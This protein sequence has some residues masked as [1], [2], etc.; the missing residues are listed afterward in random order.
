MPLEEQTIT[1]PV[2]EGAAVETVVTETPPSTQVPAEPQETTTGEVESGSKEPQVPEPARRKPSDYYQDRKTIRELKETVSQLRKWKEEQESVRKQQPQ[3]AAPEIPDFDPQ[4]FSPEHKRILLAREKSLRDAYDAKIS[5]LEQRFGGWQ[6]EKVVAES[7]RKQ[8]EALEKL[9]PK[10]SPD[11]RETIQERIDKNPERAA[12]IQEVLLSTGLNDFFNKN[13]DMAFKML[14]QEIGEAPSAANPTVLK[15]S[16]MGG[17]NSGNPGM[18]DKRT[19]TEQ[20]LRAELKKIGDQLDQNQSLRLDSKFMERK[21][22]VQDDL[23]RLVT[24][25]R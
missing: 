15:K 2:V 10:S 7:D 18:G 20:D 9:F 1:A 16:L 19:R 24:E 8:Q 12:R 14:M 25:K 22:Q 17:A 4:H 3:T 6:Q 21:R 13:P 23:Q 5:A 11:S